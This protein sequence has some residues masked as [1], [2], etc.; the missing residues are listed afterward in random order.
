MKEFKR[1]NKYLV[2]KQSDIEKYLT[3]DDKT[4]L[5]I[6]LLGVVVGRKR[7]GK[8]PNHYV[9]VNEDEPYAEQVWQLI[10]K[11]WETENKV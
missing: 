10:Q 11:Q 2:V 3:K 7:E 6:L 1:E 8:L 5:D 9:V 4:D